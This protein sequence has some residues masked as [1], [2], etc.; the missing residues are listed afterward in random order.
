MKFGISAVAGALALAWVGTA[1]AQQSGSPPA[2]Q[3]LTLPYER[4][5]WGN[6]GLSLG[7]TKLHAPCPAGSSCDLRD[8]G[9]R[10]HVGGRFNNIIGGEIGWVDFGDFPR[11]GGET[12]IAGLD[13]KLLAGIPIGENSSIFGKL[14]TAYLRTKVG[15]T[16]PGFTTGKDSHWGAT[17]GIGAQV[18]LTRNWAIRGDIDR[19]RVKFPGG[20]KDNVDS[21]MIGAQ[22]SFQ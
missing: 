5:F 17:Y 18:G 10:A 4:G 9:W 22:Y 1:F 7:R 13:L 14:G 15:G 2:G 6:A 11:G 12:S 8:G 21:Y 19:Y 20:G 16:V 3:G